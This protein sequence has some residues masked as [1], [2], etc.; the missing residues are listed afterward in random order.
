[1]TLS[2]REGKRDSLG[3]PA[4]FPFLNLGQGK[5]Q[6]LDILK[7]KVTLTPCLSGPFKVESR[8]PDPSSTPFPLFGWCFAFYFHTGDTRS[9]RLQGHGCRR[10]LGGSQLHWSPMA[11]WIQG[12]AGERMGRREASRLREQGAGGAHSPVAVVVKF[13]VGRHGDEA[14]PC[15]AQGIED[16]RG[17]IP[18]DLQKGWPVSHCRQMLDAPALVPLGINPPHP[19]LASRILSHCGVR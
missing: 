15:T 10:S 9:S 13:V 1:M 18:P 5:T 14:T 6:G 19:T 17:C 16:L 4:C 12:Q 11:L 7:R 8:V 3:D 2:L